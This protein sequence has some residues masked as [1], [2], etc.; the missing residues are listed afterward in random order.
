MSFESLEALRNQ[1][2][3][4]DRFM[5]ADKRVVYGKNIIRIPRSEILLID[6]VSAFSDYPGKLCFVSNRN[7][8]L[9]SCIALCSFKIK[10]ETVC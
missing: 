3:L 8:S 6:D 4:I 7:D 9:N 10:D 2:Q 1:S 5:G